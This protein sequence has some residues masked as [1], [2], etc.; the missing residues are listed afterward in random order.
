MGG[1]TASVEQAGA[2]EEHGT[3]AD[4][5]QGFDLGAARGDPVDEGLVVELAT[6]APA[7]G[8]EEDVE[9][10]AVL[11]GVV[12]EDA[13]AAGGDDGILGLGD[14]AY[15]KGGG[16]LTAARLIEA[17]DGKDLVGST[18]VEDLDVGEDQ[19]T[20]AFS[21]HDPLLRLFLFSEKILT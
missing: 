11:Q 9:G 8:H 19:Y 17:S 1:G 3:G 13:Q 12:G 16:L 10:R 2:T 18:K 21:L 15:L 6:G 5:G 4:R 7:A 14:Q 20:N